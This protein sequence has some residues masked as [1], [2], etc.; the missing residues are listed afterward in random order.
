M[1]TSA[2]SKTR[3]PFRNNYWLHTFIFV[4]LAVWVTT[5]VRTT[6]LNNW[7]LENLL[8]VLY[9]CVFIP[10]YRKYQFSDLSYLFFLIFLIL[11]VY[12]S[13]NTYAENP[14]G[15]WLKD[16]LNWERN[17]YD[18]IVHFTA[19]LLLAYPWRELLVG[20]LKFPTRSALIIPVIMTFTLSGTY[21][22]IEWAVAAIFFPEQGPNYLGTQGD[23]WD[24]Q[25]DSGLA[26]LGALIATSLI[27]ML[28]R[29]FRRT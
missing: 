6:D 9:L 22:I 26:V 28:Q 17:H 4:F 15:Y 2:S 7:M 5:F 23:V 24:A 16:L 14:L 13:Q 18:R 21:E 1:F 8:V 25:K 11:H 10:T 29:F 27:S 20:H 12:G 19:G 3:T